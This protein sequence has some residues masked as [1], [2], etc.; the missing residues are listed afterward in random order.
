MKSDLLHVPL[1]G[2][3]ASLGKAYSPEG[4]LVFI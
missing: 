3:P 2:E 4:S 1:C